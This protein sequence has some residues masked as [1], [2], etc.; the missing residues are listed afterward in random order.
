MWPLG[1]LLVPESDTV[2]ARAYAFYVRLY[3][4]P[5]CYILRSS[6]LVLTWSFI[7]LPKPYTLPCPPSSADDTA[8]QLTRGILEL[9]TRRALNGPQQTAATSGFHSA[10]SDMSKQ[11]K[12]NDTSSTATPKTRGKRGHAPATSS[13]LTDSAATLAFLTT[14]LTAAAASGATGRRHVAGV[15]ASVMAFVQHI[16][17]TRHV[18]VSGGGGRCV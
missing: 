16:L 3:F 11:L 13:L 5:L 4:V 17:D 9:Y 10:V 7:A 2:N 15:R 1:H 6:G 12:A 8:H 18:C 14:Y